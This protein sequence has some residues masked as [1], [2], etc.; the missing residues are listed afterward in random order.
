VWP[1]YLTQ[2][3][4]STGSAATQSQTL[5]WI[6]RESDSSR[7]QRRAPG[8]CVPLGTPLA[9]DAGMP[10]CGLD[11]PDRHAVKARCDEADVDRPLPAGMGLPG[12][13]GRRQPRQDPGSPSL[14]PRMRRSHSAPRTRH[15]SHS[16]SRST[17]ERQPRQPRHSRRAQHH[18]LAEQ[19][20][21][22]RPHLTSTPCTDGHHM[23]SLITS[24]PTSRILPTPSQ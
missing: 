24:N 23:P 6:P 15:Q 9:C 13:R 14:S 17:C 2:M 18:E 11:Q 8:R 4:E 21:P 20:L 19:L 7:R 10:E 5:E 12:I 16:N 3:I 22:A 1:A